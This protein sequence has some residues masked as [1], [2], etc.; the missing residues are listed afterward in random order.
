[1]ES[2]PR[3]NV[4]I[5]RHH[6]GLFNALQLLG[7][8]LDWTIFTPIGMDWWT[9][10]I[11]Q[12][13]VVFG[14]DRLA[15]QYLRPGT[16]EMYDPEFPDRLISGVTLMEA[17]QMD[18]G[19]VMATVQ[20]NQEGFRSFADEHNAQYAYHVGNTNQQIAWSL[21]PAVL[22][23]SEMPMHGRG[24]HIGE[25]FDSERMFGYQPPD[26]SR[27]ISS[28][29]NCMPQIAC[30]P[31]LESSRMLASD[32]D[33][34]VHGISGPDGVLKPITMVATEM[35]KSSFGWHDK[36]H[37]D[38]FGHVLNY[39]AAIGRPLIGHASHYAGKNGSVFWRDLETCI[40]LDKH[41][42]AE[43]YQLINAIVNDPPRH[44]AMCEAIRA[45]F[46]ANT[47]WAGDAEKVKGL[48]GS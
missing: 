20:E 31:D 32:W 36:Q 5:D 18:W 22:N 15:Q 29:V 48:L 38:G 17:N 26:G 46:D 30:Y 44:R 42:L 21:D 41:K 27:F 9:E 40:D 3:M 47:D 10:R 19:V 45:V 12:F 24:V 16:A 1:M 6:A 39:W 13:G 43:T 14:D 25:E 34:H 33:F 7:D 2:V 35:A 23:A 8:R 4:L 28:F 37:G 11:W